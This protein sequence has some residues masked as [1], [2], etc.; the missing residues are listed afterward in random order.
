[1]DGVLMKFVIAF[2]PLFSKPVFERVKVLLTGAILSP[3]SRTV[4]NALRVMGLSGEPHFQQFHRVLNRARWSCLIGAKILLKLLIQVFGSKDQIVI[5]FD[6]H[7]ERRRGKKIKAKGIYRD[8][9]RSS[10]SFFVKASG[11][12]WMSFMLLTEVPFAC[13]VWALPFMTI[14]CPSEKY[15]SGKGI[16]HRKLTRRA[17]QAILLIKRWLPDFQLIFVGDSSYAA[18]D[19]LNAIRAKVTMVTRLR[20]DAA[21]YKPAP[22][23]TKGQFGRPRKKG[24]RLENLTQIVKNPDTGWEKTVVNWY[25]VEKEI[26]ITSGRCVWFHVGKEAVPIRWVIVR[27]PSEEFETQA[28]LCTN[29]DGEP[30]QIVEWF[31]K[32]WQV[33]VTFEESRRH[34]GIETQRQ[35]SDKAIQRTTPCLFGLFSIITMMAQELSASGK[36]KIRSA[37]WYQKEVATFSDAIGCVRQQIWESRSFQTSENEWEMIKIPRS[38]LNTLTDTL[39]FAA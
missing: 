38:F 39:C 11:L 24:K 16:R 22:A 14:L 23:R 18:I 1:M 4:T 19:L 28:L 2:A 17:R 20:L 5:G 10:D 27:D 36:L 7:L 9:V 6:D 34:L 26:E 15:H 21:L 8:A 33:E 12:R 31:I 25:G 3:A 37:I 32:R 13:K 29:Q 30:Q 35:W